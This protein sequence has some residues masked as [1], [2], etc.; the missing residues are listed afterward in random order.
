MNNAEYEAWLSEAVVV[1]AADKVASGQWSQDASLELSRKE[2]EELLPQGLASAGNHLFKILGPSGE[3]VGDL[4]FA[5]RRKFGLPIANVYHVT[6][7][8]AHRRKGYAYHAFLALEREVQAL[9]LHGIAL[10]VFGHNHAARGLYAKLGYEPTNLRLFKHVTRAAERLANTP[11]QGQP[12][13]P[14]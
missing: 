2:H 11:P 4:W 13:T 9:E 8:Q 14:R 12:S 5:V 7:A 10:H 6:I 3:T 1:Y